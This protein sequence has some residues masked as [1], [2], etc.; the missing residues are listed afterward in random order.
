M[1][2]NAYI[3]DPYDPAKAI[4][5]KELNDP[6]RN[7]PDGFSGE[8]YPHYFGEDV[9]SEYYPLP[10]PP[11]FNSKGEIDFDPNHDVIQKR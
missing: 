5:D 4:I 10:P 11:T 2:A 6:S 1:S 7:H 9:N 3:D 8:D